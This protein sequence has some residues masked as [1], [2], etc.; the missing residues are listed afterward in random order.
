MVARVNVV[1]PSGAP[2]FSPA[3]TSPAHS[4]TKVTPAQIARLKQ[5]VVDTAAYLT[6]MKAQQA[7]SIAS[8]TALPSA[9]VEAVVVPGY[10]PPAV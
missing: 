7:A 2:G 6:R 4:G 1:T 5:H 10:P 9:D 3:I 8:L